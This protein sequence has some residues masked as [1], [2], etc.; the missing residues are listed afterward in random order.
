MALALDE[1]PLRRAFLDY[2]EDLHCAAY[3][4]LCQL[5]EQKP[6][7]PALAYGVRRLYWHAV[8]SI[9]F[10]FLWWEQSPLAY[11]YTRDPERTTS[12]DRRP[13]VLDDMWP[14]LACAWRVVGE[15]R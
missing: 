12:G 14:H 15:A 6:I 13:W 10:G 4:V 7:P 3:L 8:S 5:R 11:V 1:G 2:P 9:F